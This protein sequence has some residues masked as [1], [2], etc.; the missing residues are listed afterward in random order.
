MKTHRAPT[1]FSVRARG[2]AADHAPT[3][4]VWT[5]ELCVWCSP[6]GMGT[7]ALVVSGAGSNVRRPLLRSPHVVLLHLVRERNRLWEECVCFCGTHAAKANHDRRKSGP[8]GRLALAWGR[9]MHAP[10][11]FAR[12]KIGLVYFQGALGANAQRGERHVC[13][14]KRLALSHL[15]LNRWLAARPD[16]PARVTSSNNSHPSRWWPQCGVPTVPILSAMAG[17]G[18]STARAKLMMEATDSLWFPPSPP[19]PSALRVEP[20]RAPAGKCYSHRPSHT[21]ARHTPPPPPSP[22]PEREPERAPRCVVP[23]WLAG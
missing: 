13:S 7:G 12:C 8:R 20:Q 22:L 9:R 10:V 16:Q 14:A 17:T 4:V 19:P 23:A 2:D 6:G 21:T 3:V 15:S 5:S 18:G 11:L 1:C